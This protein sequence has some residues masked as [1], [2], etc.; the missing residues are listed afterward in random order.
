MNDAPAAARSTTGTGPPDREGANVAKGFA[1][2]GMVGAVLGFATF[3]AGLAGEWWWFA[4]LLANLRWQ[5]SLAMLGGGLLA[6]C[7]GRRWDGAVFAL[8]GCLAVGLWTPWYFGAPVA[9]PSESAEER[10]HLLTWNCSADN[11][12][13]EEAVAWLKEADPDVLVL[14]EVTPEWSLHLAKL[15][16]YGH[17]LI[18]VRD[19]N[20]GIAVLSRFPPRSWRLRRFGIGPGYGA[21]V[22]L[23]VGGRRIRLLAVHAVPPM[24]AG[25]SATN[26][27]QLAALVSAIDEGSVATIVCGDLN[28]TPWS[29]SYRR[30]VRSAELVDSAR[31]RGLPDTWNPIHFPACGLPIDHILC[32]PDLGIAERDVG[33]WLGSDHRPLWATFAW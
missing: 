2:A 28:A 7:C 1:I 29:R 9:A 26:G 31:G 23:R 11:R 3:A 15:P 22:D 24:S 25:A 21:D 5:A 27:E 10:L 13:P 8:G 4:D 18:D 33:P 19:D 17:R 12:Q 20:F 32:T 6:L 14:L 30:L 16:G